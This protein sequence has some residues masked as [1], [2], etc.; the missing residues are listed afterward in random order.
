[1]S[2]IKHRIHDVLVQAHDAQAR[3]AHCSVYV[4]ARSLRQRAVAL[5]TAVVTRL[6]VAAPQARLDESDKVFD[7]GWLVSLATMRA[8]RAH[9][10]GLELLW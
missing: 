2:L 8:L 3:L 9:R 5:Q 6:A 4:V 1:M 10:A 7:A